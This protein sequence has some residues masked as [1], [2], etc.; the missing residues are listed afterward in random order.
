MSHVF[1][2]LTDAPGSSISEASAWI[3][4]VYLIGADGTSRYTIPTSPST[5]Y[6]LLDLQ[7][8]VTVL[9]GDATIPAGDY[10]QLRLIVDSAR[11]KLASPA[12]FTNGT[13][14]VTMKV[15]SGMQTG[16][17][18]EFGG[19]IHIA[20]NQTF[21]VVDFSVLQSFVLTGPPTGPHGVLFT[22]V[23]HGVVQDVAGS[24]SGTSTPATAVLFAINASNDTVA[25]ADADPSTGA[26][27]LMF[28]PPATYTVL[29]SNTVNAHKV[30]STP[31][32]VGPGQQV[33][34]VDLSNP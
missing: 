23:L 8:G 30:T 28:L 34:G 32:V 26:Y 7:G 11:V 31:V 20:P 1:V 27:T 16:I 13:D 17:K 2:R 18:V 3:S 29:D 10:V 12:T 4:S 21:L 14:T 15:P 5:E 22:P 24:I 9:L 6:H 33:T 19:P 25:S